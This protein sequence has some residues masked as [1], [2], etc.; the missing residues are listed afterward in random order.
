MEKTLWSSL[1]EA[2]NSIEDGQLVS[3]QKLLQKL[4][5]LHSEKVS[6]GSFDIYRLMLTKIN[7]LEWIEKG[8]YKKVQK[9]P[10]SLSTSKAHKL[11]IHLKWGRPTW[12][13]WF[14]ENLEDRIK[15][16]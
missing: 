15:L 8:V 11:E 13:D 6:G 14:P 9:F 5:D 7:V 12:K 3:R 4:N 1:R 10:E 16:L 2:I